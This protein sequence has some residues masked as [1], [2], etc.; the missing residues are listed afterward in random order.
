MSPR[1]CLTYI[2]MSPGMGQ[3]CLVMSPGVGMKKMV[4]SPPS[5]HRGVAHLG[6]EL[7]ITFSYPGLCNLQNWSTERVPQTWFQL[8]HHICL[9]NS[10]LIKHH[11]SLHHHHYS[12][13]QEIIQHMNLTVSILLHNHMSNFWNNAIFLQTIYH[14]KLFIQIISISNL[15]YTI[16]RFQSLYSNHSLNKW[17]RPPSQKSHKKTL[18]LGPNSSLG[19]LSSFAYFL[20]ESRFSAQIHHSNTLKIW[21]NWFKKNYAFQNL[22]FLATLAQREA[23]HRL[24]HKILT[25]YGQKIISI[26]STIAVLRWIEARVSRQSCAETVRLI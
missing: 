21:K 24:P 1:W 25:N 9:N 23:P 16:S 26:W 22:Q 20:S 8:I 19:N 2:V 4:M 7:H 14:E 12:L 18:F 6:F 10:S 17:A 11:L 15:V 5:P 3:T 13:L